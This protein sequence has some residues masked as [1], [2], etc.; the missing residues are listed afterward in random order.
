MWKCAAG[1]TSRPVNYEPKQHFE[2]GEK[3]EQMDFEMAA[4]MSGARFVVMK[5]QLARLERALAQLMLDIQTEK[6]GYTEHYVPFMVNDNAVFGTAQLPKFGEDLFK[7]TD[8]RWLIPT[9][10]VS[11]TNTCAKAFLK[12][13]TCRCASRPIRHASALRQGRRAAIRAA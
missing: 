7:T 3:L 9:A 4:R 12:K 8:G 1:A 5:K 11:L 13:R 6:N 2:L 10:E